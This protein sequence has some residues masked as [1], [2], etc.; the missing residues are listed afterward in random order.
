MKRMSAMV[1]A[2]AAMGCGE[3]V[4]TATAPAAGAPAPPVAA[5]PAPP[6]FSTCQPGSPSGFCGVSFGIPTEQ[7]IEAFPAPLEP[8]QGS[9]E[10]TDPAACR[11]L[12]ANGV[13]ETIAFLFENEKVGRVDVMVPGPET[14]GG[15]GV[16][17][18]EADVRAAHAAVTAVPDKYDPAIT[19]LEVVEGP[20]KIIYRLRN[21]EVFAWRAGVPPTVDYVEGCG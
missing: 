12:L 21:G 17:A 9:V 1:C 3:P 10:P 13:P 16:G 7:A 19:Q 5:P 15:I 8:V 4:E 11:I 20:G 18:S 6:P 14:S 2:L